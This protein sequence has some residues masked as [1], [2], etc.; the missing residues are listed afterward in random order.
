MTYTGLQFPKTS[1]TLLMEDVSLDLVGFEYIGK[2]VIEAESNELDQELSQYLL[3]MAM[4]TGAHMIFVEA[5][6]VRLKGYANDGLIYSIYME[7]KCRRYN[8]KIFS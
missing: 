6:N 7:A 4:F 2:L 1:W 3:N 8:S 5:E